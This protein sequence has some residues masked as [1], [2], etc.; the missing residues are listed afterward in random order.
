LA[1]TASGI[2]GYFESGRGGNW[3]LELQSPKGLRLRPEG[4][5]A[6]V[7]F[8]GRGSEPPTNQLEGLGEHCK[9]P[10][11]GSGA[12]PQPLNGFCIILYAQVVPAV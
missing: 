8:L 11:R 7:R 2:R 10:Q 3:G 6:E 12:E 9:L 5:K 4:L 1:T